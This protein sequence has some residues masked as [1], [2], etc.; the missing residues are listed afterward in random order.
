MEFKLSDYVRDI[1]NMAR[2]NSCSN[3]KAM[4]LFLAN[5]ATMSDRFKGASNL[6]FRQLGQLWN[7][8][9]N[10]ERVKQKADV[11]ARLMRSTR[12]GSAE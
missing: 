2:E 11:S 9:P 3:E 10:D 5:L 4:Q 12:G 6:N 8:L 1:Q 7:G